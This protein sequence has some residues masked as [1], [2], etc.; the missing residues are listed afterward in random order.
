MPLAHT[1]RIVQGFRMICINLRAARLA[2][3]LAVILSA[4]APANAEQQAS[5]LASTIAE[6]KQKWP[7][8]H[9]L[10]SS[11]VQSLIDDGKAVVFDVRSKEEYDT[12]H[13][14]GAIL[15]DPATGKDAFLA[16]NAAAL[17]G[18]TAVFYCAV[19]MR[20]SRLA[21]RVGTDALKAAGATDSVNL[22]GGIFAWNWEGRPLVD[23][24]GPTGKVHGYDAK[25]G[26]LVKPR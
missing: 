20:S 16:A 10:P 17:T 25:W 2:I 23:A 26:K 15:V 22:E 14:P 4:I 9:H 8:L 7:S 3:A 1:L 13:L 19:G 6:V 11:G 21:D 12:S 5:P 18:K 24:N